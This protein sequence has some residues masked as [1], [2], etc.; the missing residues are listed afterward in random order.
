MAEIFLDGQSKN[1]SLLTLSHM[2]TLLKF[3]SRKLVYFML[4]W[5]N[6]WTE[7]KLICSNQGLEMTDIVIDTKT[8]EIIKGRHVIY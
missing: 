5:T 4:K 1:S 8:I 6:N 3:I 2:G 7:A